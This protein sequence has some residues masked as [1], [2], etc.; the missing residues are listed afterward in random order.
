MYRY[1]TNGAT[2]YEVSLYN[3]TVRALVKENQSHQ[4]YDD[5]WADPRRHDV[6]ASNE[7]EARQMIAERF[8]PEEGFVV[9]KVR[10]ARL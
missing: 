6:V 3:S 10:L 7:G 8:P 4:L 1:P 9:Q 5:M 2:A